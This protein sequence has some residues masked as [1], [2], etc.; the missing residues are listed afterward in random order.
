MFQL[1]KPKPF[2]KLL[3]SDP[4][5]NAKECT[6]SND[7]EGGKKPAP[8]TTPAKEKRNS[9]REGYAQ[10]SWNPQIEKISDTKQLPDSPPPSKKK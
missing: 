7:K 6:M 4:T 2:V 10:D 8:T 5:T 9:V 1:T 3:V